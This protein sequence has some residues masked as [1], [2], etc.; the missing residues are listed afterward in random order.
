VTRLL[1]GLLLAGVAAL[2]LPVVVMALVMALAATAV[3]GCAAAGLA[4]H[5]PVPQPARRWVAITHEACPELPQAWIAAVMAQESAFR[6]DAYA[7]DGNGGTWGLLQINQTVWAA[8]YGGG[9]TTDRDHDG[10]WDIRQPDIHAHVGGRYLC[11][12]LD[13]V[14]ALLEGRPTSPAARE[15]TDLDALLIAH[16]AGESRLLTYPDIPALT[17]GYLTTVRQRTADWAADDYRQGDGTCTPP[18]GPSAP[19]GAPAEV[20]RMVRTAQAYVG[21]RSGWYRMC[22]GLACRLYGYANSGYPTAYAHWRTLLAAGQA[23]PGRCPPVGAFVFW[24]SSSP[25]GHVATVVATDGTCRPDGIRLVTNDWGDAAAGA[26]GGVYLVTLA[27]I[28]NGWMT[29]ANYLGWTEPI[30][31]GARLPA[32]TRHPAP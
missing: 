32:G 31:A 1:G 2:A 12:R 20:T 6:P 28:E 21:L 23:H 29:S 9:W 3:T 8:A 22:D 24:T 7:D 30:C 19:A 11:D 17:A 10:V 25:A 16:N 27:Q 4:A 5:A 18:V 15:L 14:R 26:Q 13:G